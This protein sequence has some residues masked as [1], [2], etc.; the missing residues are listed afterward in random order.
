VAAVV[1]TYI[2]RAV[3]AVGPLGVGYRIPVKIWKL[4]VDPGRTKHTQVTIMKLVYIL[5]NPNSLVRDLKIFS[6]LINIFIRKQ[7]I[8]INGGSMF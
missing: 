5:V 2:G 7:H 3:D 6:A 1:G 8:R 4:R